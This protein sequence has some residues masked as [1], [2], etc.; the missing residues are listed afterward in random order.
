MLKFESK[1]ENTL[2]HLVWSSLFVEMPIKLIRL[3]T[4]YLSIGTLKLEHIVCHLVT[5]TVLYLSVLFCYYI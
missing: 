5:I 4:R 1:L 3:Q 2:Y